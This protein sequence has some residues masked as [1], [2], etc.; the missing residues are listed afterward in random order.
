MSWK[1]YWQREWSRD[2]IECLSSIGR[3]IFYVYPRESALVQ[4]RGRQPAI[5][6]IHRMFAAGFCI[7]RA[8]NSARTDHDQRTVLVLAQLPGNLLSGV[9]GSG[10]LAEANEA[11]W[12]FLIERGIG[13]LAVYERRADVHHLGDPHLQ[14]TLYDVACAVDIDVEMDFSARF[15]EG[16]N[17]GQVDHPVVASHTSTQRRSVG[18]IAFDEGDLKF[19]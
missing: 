12:A 10:V 16:V 7:I 18:H 5:N 15:P 11:D 4:N 3:D 1:R 19:F 2:E 6:Q 8:Q 9:L 17:V 13:W 14:C